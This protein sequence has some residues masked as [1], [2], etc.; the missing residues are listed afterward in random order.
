M[1]I[2][3]GDVRQ[4]V[5]HAIHAARRA[6]AERRALAAAAEQDGTAALEGVA[7]PVFKAVAAVLRAEG[8]GFR[9]LTP[10][11]SV[12]LAAEAAPEDFIEIVLDT[13]R[14]PPALVG[15]VSRAWGR[16]VLVDEQVVR[17]AP[18]LRDLTTDD[19][20]EIVLDR[21]GPFVER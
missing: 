11:G 16:R 17:E 15:R 13:T 12:R 18:A 8:Y 9:V 10:A 5:L 2:A 14:D 21:L 1:E 4:R 6:A 19:A 20:L 7:A 3:A